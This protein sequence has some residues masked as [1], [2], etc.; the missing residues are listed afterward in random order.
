V[1]A[2]FTDSAD[3]SFYLRHLRMKTK[4]GFVKVDGTKAAGAAA[5]QDAG[6]QSG[7]ARFLQ[8]LQ[9]F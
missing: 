2:D 5:V 6:A 1:S 3:F 4:P 7:Y 9:I 8:R